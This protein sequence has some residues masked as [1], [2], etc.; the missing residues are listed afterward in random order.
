MMVVMLLDPVIVNRFEDVLFI[1]SKMENGS[2][3]L[4]TVPSISL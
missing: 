2:N 1:R 4:R 3:Y